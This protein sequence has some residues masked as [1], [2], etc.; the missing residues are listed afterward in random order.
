MK[1]FFPFAHYLALILGAAAITLRLI[2]LLGGTDERDLYPANHPAWIALCLLAVAA[3]VFFFLVSRHTEAK[4]S[5]RQNFPASLPGALG[6]LAG[7]AAIAATGLTE[8]TDTLGLVLGITSVLGGGAL[9]YGGWLRLKGRKTPFFVHMLPCLYFALRIFSMGRILG[10]EPEISRYL[11]RFLAALATLMAAYQLWGFDVGLGHR[12]K[13][14]FWSLTA[15]VLSMAAIPGSP[16]KLLYLGTAL[17][18]ITNLCSLAPARRARRPIAVPT[19][20]ELQIHPVE[21]P[22]PTPEITPDEVEPQ[23]EAKPEEMTAEEIIAWALED[24]DKM[25]D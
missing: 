23:V 12:N 6:C 5:Y 18:L 10:A 1:K 8:L 21:A 20:E 17:W 25:T 2:M 24:L 9:I 4:R 7:G 16:D 15:T 14:L 3:T 19:Y 11:F 13:S 22:V